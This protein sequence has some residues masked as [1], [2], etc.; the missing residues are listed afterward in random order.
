M[1]GA[2]HVR[3]QPVPVPLSHPVK[4]H[5]RDISELTLRPLTGKDLRIC[6]A[7]YRIGRA[8]EEGIV[9]AQAVSAMIS[10][11]AGVPISSVDQLAAV[12]WF[13]CWSAIQSFLDTSSSGTSTA[14]TS[15]LTTSTQPPSGG[16]SNT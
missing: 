6:G 8:G 14:N 11:L 16:T 1:S 2:Q 7:P 4:A 9:D 15:S 10:E 5:G 3:P 12:D 13:A